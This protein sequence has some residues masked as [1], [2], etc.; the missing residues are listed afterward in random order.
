MIF[1]NWIEYVSIIIG[2]RKSMGEMAQELAAF[3]GEADANQFAKRYLKL[4]YLWSLFS[5][6][7]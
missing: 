5:D 3:M 7:D 6:F 1:S 4:H 2:N